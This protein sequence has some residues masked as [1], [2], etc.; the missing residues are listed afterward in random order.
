MAMQDDA[1]D[2]RAFARSARAF[3][4]PSGEPL[5]VLEDIDISIAQR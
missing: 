5:P 2:H 3:A 1:N 4:K